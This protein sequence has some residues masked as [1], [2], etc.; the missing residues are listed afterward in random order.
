[1]EIKVNTI[2][3]AW[4]IILRKILENG[5]HVKIKID[6]K[7]V[8]TV[9]AREPI[10]VTVK[11]PLVDMVPKGSLWPSEAAL[12]QYAKDVIENRATGHDYTY[13]ERLRSFPVVEIE[14]D[15][16]DGDIVDVEYDQINYMC[17]LLSRDETSRQAI[18]SLWKVQTDE[19]G[20]HPPCLLIVDCC[21]RDDKLNMV[22]YIRSNDMYGAWPENMY[23]FVR[24]NIYMVEKI[25]SLYRKKVNLYRSGNKYIDEIRNKVN[26]ICIA[27]YNS[28][29]DIIGE[30]K[31]YNDIEIGSI[32]AISSKAHIYERDILDACK[33]IG[34]ENLSQ[35]W[36]SEMNK[37]SIDSKERF[38]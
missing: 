34:N 37:F 12:E 18:A 22:V 4:P 29:A 17:E 14:G 8:D 5:R 11:T 31:N 15:P 23:L 9:E 7:M 36:L 27:L 20:N 2:K 30:E 33:I 28:Y 1:M 3:E 10:M 35:N 13:G 6:G 32:T 21:I 19:M 26:S 38:A 16:E 24:L 25:N